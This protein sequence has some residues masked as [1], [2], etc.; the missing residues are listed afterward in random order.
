MREL[1]VRATTSFVT[2]VCCSSRQDDCVCHVA[3]PTLEVYSCVVILGFDFDFYFLF[4]YFFFFAAVF[5]FQ[6]F[7]DVTRSILIFLLVQ[8]REFSH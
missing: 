6:K 8:F 2:R 1:S 3:W 4:I 5:L 7:D